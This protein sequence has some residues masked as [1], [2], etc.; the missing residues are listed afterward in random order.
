[1][2]GAAVGVIKECLKSSEIAGPNA[3]QE[4]IR[5]QATPYLNQEQNCCHSVGRDRWFT[6]KAKQFSRTEICA[7][8]STPGPTSV[9]HTRAASGSPDWR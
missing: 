1:M 7:K 2:P 3:Q 9:C 8:Q 5:L 6:P 4:E